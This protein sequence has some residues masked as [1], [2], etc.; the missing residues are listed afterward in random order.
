MRR[1]A[2]IMNAADTACYAAKDHGRNRV[3]FFEEDATTFSKRDGEVEWV[4]H[5]KRA[6]NEKIGKRAFGSAFA[7][8]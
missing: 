8:E 4:S 5:A 3:M 7:A 6:L 2:Q 1:L